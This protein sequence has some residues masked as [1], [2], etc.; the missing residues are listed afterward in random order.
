VPRPADKELPFLIAGGGIGGLATALSLAAIGKASVVFEKRAT[1][2]EDGAGIQVG[3]NGVHA[4]RRLGIADAVE[5]LATAPHGLHIMDGLNNRRIAEVSLGEVI[6]ARHGAPYW[7]L[8]RSDLHAALLQAARNSPAISVQMSSPVAQAANVALNAV[9]NMGPSVCVS[10]DGGSIHQG[11]ALIVAEGLWSKLK[12]SFG[13][14][15]IY[16]GKRA[17]RTVIPTTP[18]MP[19]TLRTETTIWLK[20]GLHAV[21]Y[22]VRSGTEIAIV[23]IISHPDPRLGWGDTVEQQS[24]APVI[25][26]LPEDLRSILS[27]ANAWRSW[28][29]MTAAPLAQW[30]DGR[31]A[32]LGDAAHPILPFLA[33]GAVMALEDAVVMADC[34]AKHPDLEVA[35]KAYEKRRQARTHRVGR[36]SERNGKIYHLARPAATVRNAVLRAM[37]PD[38]LLSRFDW[39]YGWRP[40]FS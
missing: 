11:A 25:A 13:S 22:P 33:Q 37:P 20:P 36:A 17:F 30:T 10:F 6:A 2:D 24:L 38:T 9:A 29:L 35:F 28:P 19:A 40:D 26:S 34:V 32:L 7:T 1:F 18:N 16:S 31:I 27:A 14:A 12:H 3:P 5:A 21:H 8:R 39:I 15:P 23:L 4:L